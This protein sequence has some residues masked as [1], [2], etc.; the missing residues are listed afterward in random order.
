MELI[1]AS[2]YSLHCR[3]SCAICEMKIIRFPHP[4]EGCGKLKKYLVLFA[5]LFY[6]TCFIWLL[7][8]KGPNS[9]VS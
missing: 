5:S 9:R 2:V 8:T 1:V 3:H 6:D 7:V 4:K